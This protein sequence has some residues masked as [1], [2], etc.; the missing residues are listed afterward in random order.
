[1]TYHPD[2]KSVLSV[3]NLWR[4]KNTVLQRDLCLPPPSPALI[5]HRSFPL[6]ESAIYPSVEHPQTF[7]LAPLEQL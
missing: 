4:L 5:Y 3:L 1:M 6:K 2:S 7:A